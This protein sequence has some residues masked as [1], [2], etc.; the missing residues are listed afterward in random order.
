MGTA[1]KDTNTK[2]AGEGGRLKMPIY[3]IEEGGRVAEVSA[4]NEEDA[5]KKYRD[6]ATN[7][8]YQPKTKLGKY[9]KNVALAFDQ[10]GAALLGINHDETISSHLGKAARGDYEMPWWGKPV[11]HM[12]EKI[13]PGHCEAA[14]EEDRGFEEGRVFANKRRKKQIDGYEM[15][16][17]EGEEERAL[18]E[19]AEVLRA[20]PVKNVEGE[21]E[22]EKTEL[23]TRRYGVK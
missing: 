21:D 23:A 14:I 16:Q 18:I 10:L 15:E 11:Y 6:K 9:G 19:L 13:Q 17:K 1:R 2:K 12:L 3:E 4:E 7:F 20:I 8:F 5:I 22:R